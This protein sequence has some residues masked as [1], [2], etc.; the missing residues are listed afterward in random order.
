MPLPLPRRVGLASSLKVA[1]DLTGR[2][3][4]VVHNVHVP[5]QCLKL[6]PDPDLLAAGLI[7]ASGLWTLS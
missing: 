4:H 7:Q 5:C 3:L 6:P 1:W 2:R